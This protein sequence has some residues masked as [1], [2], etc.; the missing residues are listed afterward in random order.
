MGEKYVTRKETD[1]WGND[2]IVTRRGVTASDVGGAI[3]MGAGLLIAA[4]Q[5]SQM[6]AAASNAEAAH[7]YFEN[8]DYDKA[9]TSANKLIAMSDKEAQTIG[10][11]FKAMA[12]AGQRSHDEA[13]KEFNMTIDL[14]HTINQMNALAIAYVRRGACYYH[15]NEIAAAMRDFTSYIQIQPNED[16]GYY[17]QGLALVKL[18]DLDQALANLTRA[19]SINPGDS[20]NYRERAEIYVR[21]QEPGKAIED[22]SRA[23]TLNPQDADCYRVRAE[24]YDGMNDHEHAI[25]DYSR[26]VELAPDDLKS[27]KGRAAVYQRTGDTARSAADMGKVVQEEPLQETYRAYFQA[28][29]TAYDHGITAIYTQAD[30]QTTP[31]WGSAVLKIIGTLIVC[32]FA[33]SFCASAAVS[34]RES[35]GGI[36]LLFLVL[37]VALVWGIIAGTRSQATNKVKASTA[38]LQ[39]RAANDVQ[40]PGFEEFFSQFLQAKK[41]SRL[42][43]LPARTRPFFTSGPGSHAVQAY[44][45]RSQTQPA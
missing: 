25:A 19:I 39:M 15:K 11:F 17:W 6:K 2:Q 41:E 1:I 4:H 30:T 13:I 14:G 38:Y 7:K 12:L 9:I 10:H 45:T 26:A 18:G 35:P 31:N 44:S 20:D 33:M 28:A 23:I 21:R 43:E 34:L 8:G 32:F 24:L 42:Q 36:S 22:L 5:N 16:T 27:Y 40:M 29:S 37:M 3:G